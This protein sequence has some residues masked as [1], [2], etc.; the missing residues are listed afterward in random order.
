[1]H[2]K[3]KV[4]FWM[5][6]GPGFIER[7]TGI[8]TPRVWDRDT[9]LASGTP[10]HLP[11][12]TAMDWET[13]QCRMT[14]QLKSS[15][16]T[17]ILISLN[18]TVEILLQ[19]SESDILVVD[20]SLWLSD[21]MTLCLERLQPIMANCPPGPLYEGLKFS[22]YLLNCKVGWV[23]NELDSV[24]ISIQ[25]QKLSLWSSSSKKGSLSAVKQGDCCCWFQS[26]KQM[27]Q[28]RKVAALP[29]PTFSAFLPNH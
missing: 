22:K 28:S 25:I 16:N 13:Q 14:L 12:D 8:V 19:N 27:Q 7:K 21:T 1:M 26:R 5:E 4:V 10:W 23:E 15:L 29:M 3:C 11:W 6:E 18:W 17:F 9:S 2:R 20:C 24:P